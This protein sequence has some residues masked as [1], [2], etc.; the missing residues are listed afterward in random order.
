MVETAVIL[1]LAGVC[2]GYVF[3]AAAW[4]ADQRAEWARAAAVLKAALR[5]EIDSLA[6][7]GGVQYGLSKID[8]KVLPQVPLPLSP[9][10]SGKDKRSHQRER[11]KLWR[12]WARYYLATC[13]TCL[14]FHGVW[15]SAAI[16]A[17]IAAATDTAG[18]ATWA[19]APPVLGAAGTVHLAIT[20]AGN[21]LELW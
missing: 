14:G 16:W 13:S 12:Q 5:Y 15:I 4:N 19:T 10:A 1:G 18:P 6:E 9:D 2:F 8:L 21:R 7:D 17:A 3:G 11:R 20:S